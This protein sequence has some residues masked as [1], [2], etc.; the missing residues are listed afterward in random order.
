MRFPLQAEKKESFHVKVKDSV[1]SFSGI[2]NKMNAL[3]ENGIAPADICWYVLAS[4]IGGVEKATVRRWR[5][6]PACLYCVPWWGSV[7]PATAGDDDPKLRHRLCRTSFF[8]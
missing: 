3:A 7:K 4:I 1:F 8:H 5:N 6:Y 2:E